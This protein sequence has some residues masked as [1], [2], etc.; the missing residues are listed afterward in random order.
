VFGSPD[1]YPLD[2][3]HA[4]GSRILS[5]S[6]TLADI[7]ED[8]ETADDD[9]EAVD[10]QGVVAM[11]P[12]ADMLNAAKDRD[13]AHLELVDGEYRMVTTARICAGDQIFNTYSSPPDA[14]LLRKYGHLEQADLSDALR[15]DLGEELVANYPYGNDGDEVDIETSLVLEV[16]KVQGVQAEERVDWWLEEADMDE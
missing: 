14:E 2:H 8:Q 13:N 9:S 4:Q 16:I 7:R 10:D 3:F 15:T 11:V 6:F 1:D 5:R 12:M